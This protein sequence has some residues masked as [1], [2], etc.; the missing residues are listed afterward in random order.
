MLRTKKRLMALSCKQIMENEQQKFSK[1]QSIEHPS[2][3]E[4]ARA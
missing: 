4:I 1:V 3:Q 2:S